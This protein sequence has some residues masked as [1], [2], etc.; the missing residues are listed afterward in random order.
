MPYK[1]RYKIPSAKNLVHDELEVR[2]FVVVY[3]DE[4]GAIFGEEFSE[5]HESWVH[6]AE[7][8]VVSGEVFGFR[9]YYSAEPSLYLRRV[10][11]IVIYPAF[12]AC[13]VGWVYVDALYLA[14]VFRQEGLESEEVIAMND[15]VLEAP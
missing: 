2:L 12:V 14:F 15:F 4:Y 5:E 6:H 3:G 11:T 13:V 8:F 1:I 10:H 7:P 9:A